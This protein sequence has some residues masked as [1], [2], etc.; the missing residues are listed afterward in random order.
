MTQKMLEPEQQTKPVTWRPE[1]PE[2]L[3]QVDEESRIERRPRTQTIQILLEEALAA[4]RQR[5]QLPAG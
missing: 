3:E 5:R 1:N 4:R 2:T